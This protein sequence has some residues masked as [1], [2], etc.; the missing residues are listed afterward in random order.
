MRDNRMIT[1]KNNGCEK[2][3]QNL[4]QFLVDIMQPLTN[5]ITKNATS[6]ASKQ[7]PILRCA[8]GQG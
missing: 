3:G 5:G 8:V 6:K 1:I 2:Y 4:D 7:T